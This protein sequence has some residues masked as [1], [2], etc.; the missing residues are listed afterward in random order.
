MIARASDASLS[1]RHSPERRYGGK[2]PT[3]DSI[4]DMAVHVLDNSKSD[5]DLKR[6]KITDRAKERRPKTAI[7]DARKVVNI[8]ISRTGST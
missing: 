6:E 5:Y 1:S 2:E 8:A 4:D 3:H 7:R